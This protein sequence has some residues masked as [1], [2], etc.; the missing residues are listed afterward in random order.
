ARAVPVGFS[1]NTRPLRQ[2]LVGP[3]VTSVAL[4]VPGELLFRGDNLLG[5]GGPEAAE[6]L[7]LRSLAWRRADPP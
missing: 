1:I 5:L 2:A 3:G 7:T 4:D 6:V